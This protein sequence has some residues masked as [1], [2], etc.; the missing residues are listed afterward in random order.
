MRVHYLPVPASS[1][2]E[3]APAPAA[4]EEGAPS[5]A[6]GLPAASVPPPASAPVPVQASS[7]SKKIKLV[8]VEDGRGQPD[9]SSL[10]ASVPNNAT[11]A[12]SAAATPPMGNCRLD[13]T[14][15]SAVLQTLRTHMFLVAA[16]HELSAAEEAI[17]L[18]MRIIAGFEVAEILMLTAGVL[19]VAAIVFA[20]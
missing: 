15:R 7:D 16:F 18:K 5:P 10:A 3:T 8:S 9:T 2:T 6:L 19:L 11:P 20:I 17:M 12:A 13:V 4:R 14:L 1:A